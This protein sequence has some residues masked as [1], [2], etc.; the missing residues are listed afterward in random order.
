MLELHVYSVWYSSR[1]F[2]QIST[3][4][5]PTCTYR[6]TVAGMWGTT[7]CWCPTI[8]PLQMCR[9]WW[10]YLRQGLASQGKPC[11]LWTRYR[12][13]RKFYLVNVVGICKILVPVPVWEGIHKILF[14]ESPSLSAAGCSTRRLFIDLIFTS[15]TGFLTPCLYFILSFLLKFIERNILWCFKIDSN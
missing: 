12:T 13:W 9:L 11:G 6:L 2:E 8:S 5:V 14:D 4:P 10:P 1:S 15:T 7:C 3:V